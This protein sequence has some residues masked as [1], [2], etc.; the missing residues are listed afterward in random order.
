MYNAWH[1][2]G[3]IRINPMILVGAPSVRKVD[4]NRSVSLEVFDVVMNVIAGQQVDTFT[5]R[6]MQARDL[7]IFE[8][9]RGLGLRASEM[10]HAKMSAFHQVTDVSNKTRYWM[11]HV[12]AETGK[13]GKERE[14]PVPPGVLQ[15]LLDYRA[16]FGIT[17]LSPAD[18]A[19]LLSPQT[20][21]VVIAAKAIKR[22]Q[23]RRFFK[24]WREI[25]TRQGLYKIV[26]TRLAQ[27]ADGLEK[28]GD[29]WA[30]DE[31]KKAS[32]HFLRHTF[33]KAKVADG[34]DMRGLSGVLG[35]SSIA[36][37]MIYTEQHALDA[38]RAYE[39]SAPGSV[40]SEKST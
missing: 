20:R 25:A 17:Q 34:L 1:K 15:T 26:K 30:A 31:L 23:D 38:A 29:Q 33:A 6:Q 37:S 35:Y 24:A 9:L 5:E 7:F 28:S 14:I 16:A 3:Y 21:S 2:T 40:A 36:T 19:L 13:G 8:A 27:A 39:S 4:I 22:T 12:T 18:T 10:V 11:F 32:P